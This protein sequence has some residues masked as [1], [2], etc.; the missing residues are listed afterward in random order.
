MINLPVLPH[1]I[2]QVEAMIRLQA[3]VVL[4]RNQFFIG[5]LK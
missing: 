1:S 3:E 2:D 5:T 4:I